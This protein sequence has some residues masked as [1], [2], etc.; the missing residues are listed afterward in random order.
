MLRVYEVLKLHRSRIFISSMHLEV[1]YL[2]DGLEAD[3]G[4]LAETFLSHIC[5]EFSLVVSLVMSITERMLEECASKLHDAGE[6]DDCDVLRVDELHSSNHRPA[7]FQ[8]L[9]EHRPPSPSKML[10][11][12]STPLCWSG[13]SIDLLGWNSRIELT[14][15][16]A[17]TSNVLLTVLLAKAGRLPCDFTALSAEV[18]SSCLAFAFGCN[19]VPEGSMVEDLEISTLLAKLRRRKHEVW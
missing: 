7:S 14:I 18:R 11:F 4:R 6:L 19:N 10:N 1:H 13:D 15:E 17:C 9:L 12:S 3:I 5:E 2:Y 16:S 8:D